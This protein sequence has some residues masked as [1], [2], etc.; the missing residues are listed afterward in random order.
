MPIVISRNEGI[1][2]NAPRISQEQ[3]DRLWAAF[4]GNWI[5]NHPEEFRCMITEDES[6]KPAE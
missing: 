4:V 5:H 2:L 3:Q 6:D 1:T